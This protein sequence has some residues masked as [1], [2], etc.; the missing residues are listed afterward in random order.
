M[1]AAAGVR[2]T[3]P[4]FEQCFESASEVVDEIEARHLAASTSPEGEKG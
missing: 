4:D 1:L 3:D 2:A